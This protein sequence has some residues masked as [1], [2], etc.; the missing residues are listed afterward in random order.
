M[1]A[2]QVQEEDSWAAERSRA[3]DIAGHG[4]DDGPCLIWRLSFWLPLLMTACCAVAI[5]KADAATGSVA[6]LPESLQHAEVCVTA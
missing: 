3:R 4:P 5:S 1:K 2:E 6:C